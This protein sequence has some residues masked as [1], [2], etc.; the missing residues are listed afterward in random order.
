VFEQLNET[1]DMKNLHVLLLEEDHFLFP[2]SIHVLR[3]LS[4]KILSDIDVV[5]LAHFEKLKQNLDPARLNRYSKAIWHTSMHNTGLL[6]SRR[7][8]KQ[9]KD[10]SNAFCTY[11]DY[12]WDWTLQQI[13]QTCFNLPLVAIYPVFSRV[14]HIGTCGTHHKGKNCDPKESV[15]K[16]VLMYANKA[17]A[18]YADKFELQGVNTA[19]R[20]IRKSNGGWSDPRDIQ[21]CKSFF[22]SQAQSNFNLDIKV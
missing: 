15:D 1:R 17:D 21:L 16:L 10:C 20:K 5:S 8:F 2:D 9:I 11:D 19:I 14:I 22:Y 13:S 6:L 4:E 7:Q 12:N 18:F 3:K